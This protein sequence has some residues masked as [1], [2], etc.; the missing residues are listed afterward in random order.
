MH[1]YLEAHRRILFKAYRR[2]LAADSALQSARSAA[3]IWLP[4]APARKTMLI[5]DPGSRV[6]QLC[7]RRDRALTRL[8]LA[9]QA[10]KEAEIRSR[11]KRARVVR[12]IACD[13]TAT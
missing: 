2:Y 13:I 8:K 11:N 1:G 5:G 6:R 7:E 3:L 10:L 12:L 9:R 4:E